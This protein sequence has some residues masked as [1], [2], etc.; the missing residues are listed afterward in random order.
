MVECVSGINN[1]MLPPTSAGRNFMTRNVT[2]IA[3]VFR[4]RTDNTTKCYIT[5]VCW[6]VAIFRFLSNN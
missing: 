3:E 5:S 1:R 4:G 2:T 6:E